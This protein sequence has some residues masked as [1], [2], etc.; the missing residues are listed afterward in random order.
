MNSISEATVNYRSVTH[1]SGNFTDIATLCSTTR[2]NRCTLDTKKCTRELK[3]PQDSTDG[4]SHCGLF[5]DEL[6]QKLSICT[7]KVCSIVRFPQT[8]HLYFFS[9]IFSI[10]LFPPTIFLS[11]LRNLN[12]SP[13]STFTIIA[14]S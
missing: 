12:I 1:N 10:L 5:P 6:C 8:F 4:R 7:T 11:L 3:E 14:N 2:H 9:L 13:R